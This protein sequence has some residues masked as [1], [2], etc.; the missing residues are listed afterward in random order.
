VASFTAALAQR[1]EHNQLCYSLLCALCVRSDDE[2]SDRESECDRP[3]CVLFHAVDGFYRGGRY[4]QVTGQLLRSIRL[5]YMAHKNS[6]VGFSLYVNLQH[7]TYD[8]GTLCRCHLSR[9]VQQQRKD[10]TVV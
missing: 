6:S 7:S 4:W 2:H 9:L 1:N 8:T 3:V 5:L 10:A